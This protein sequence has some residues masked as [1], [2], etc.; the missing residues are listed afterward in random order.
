MKLVVPS[1]GSTAQMKSWP[2]PGR[3]SISSP[4]MSWPGKRSARRARMICSTCPSTSETGSRQCGSC[5]WH[6]LV[7]DGEK[8]AEAVHDLGARQAS[9]L[10]RK[11][12]DLGEKARRYRSPLR[13]RG[14]QASVSS[15]RPLGRHHFL[16]LHR[17][18]W[19]EN[20]TGGCSISI[21]TS[22]F[23]LGNRLVSDSERAA[24]PPESDPARLLHLHRS[25]P[26]LRLLHPFQHVALRPCRHIDDVEA[27]IAGSACVSRRFGPTN[28]MFMISTSRTSCLKGRSSR[29]SFALNGFALRSALRKASRPRST[30]LAR[31]PSSGHLPGRDIR[32]GADAHRFEEAPALERPLRRPDV[33]IL[34]AAVMPPGDDLFDRAGY[35]ERAC[36]IVRGA[37]RQDRRLSPRGPSAR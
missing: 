2:R 18:R 21:T 5:F 22:A 23:A 33:Q 12:L 6:A 19:N 35:S 7:A 9:K 34:L 10:H 29:V 4:R 1:I 28:L 32:Q 8:L 27:A 37:E 11:R 16:L 14:H 36:D 24:V 3:S 15:H 30:C 25:R 20:F 13:H 31:V 17:S 26:S